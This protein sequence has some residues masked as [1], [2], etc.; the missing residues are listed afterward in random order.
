MLRAP[1]TEHGIDII[2]FLAPT[3]HDERLKTVLTGASGYLYY[4]SFSGVTGTK[5]FVEDQVRA[6][7][8]RIRRAT[9]IPVAVGFGIR[10]PEQAGQVGAIAD[11]VIVGTAIVSKIA[12]GIANGVSRDHLVKQVLEFCASLAK[13]VHAARTAKVVG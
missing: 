9:D 2:R 3:T 7:V 11:G 13:S 5:S 6:A 4:A 10:T 12:E 1:A 8:T